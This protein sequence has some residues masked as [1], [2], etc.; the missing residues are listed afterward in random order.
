MDLFLMCIVCRGF[1]NEVSRKDAYPLSRVD[2]TL[3]ELKDA[4]FYTPIY[5]ASSFWQVRVRDEDVHKAAFHTH[6]GLMEWDAVPFGLCNAPTIIQRMMNDIMRD[7]LRK[8]VT[9]YLDDVC[10]YNRTLE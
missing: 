5:L 10:V 9:V 7:F 3:D 1:I 8:F 4:K 6:D 2:D